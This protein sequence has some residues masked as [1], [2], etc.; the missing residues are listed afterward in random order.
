MRSSEDGLRRPMAA[1]WA[2][3]ATAP[4]GRS[5]AARRAR[6][7]SFDV[8]RL[9]ALTAIVA[10]HAGAPGSHYTAW[11][12]PALAIISAALAACRA[13]PLPM[14][15]RARR[16]G[17]RLLVP[18]LFWCG[19][20]GAVELASHLRHGVSILDELGPRVLATGTSV[21]LWYL[22]FAF[23]MLLSVEV[24]RR[25]T[26]RLPAAAVCWAAVATAALA[27]AAL[28]V[29]KPYLGDAGTPGPQWLRS[30]PAPFLGLAVG[31]AMRRDE[32]GG[33]RLLAVTAAAAAACALIAVH[34]ED[35]L[36]ARYGIALLLVAPASTWRP[37][38]PR[39][40]AEAAGLGMGVYLVHM[41]VH[42]AVYAVAN[43]LPTPDLP[44]AG[45]ALLVIAFSFAAAAALARSPL[46]RFV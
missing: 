32:L 15:S 8:L 17:G 20:Y 11:R 26:D 33:R 6:L 22:P 40:L 34:L 21:H 23:A 30:L 13:E 14:A 12:L 37:E 43:R 44:P 29:D 24:V 46:R 3:R 5:E 41:L 10:F 39:W 9:A 18:W 19:V 45:Q 28:A 4:A 42:R 36:A 1:A 2:P 7:A 35:D 27:L 25:A 16:M 31:T 38:P